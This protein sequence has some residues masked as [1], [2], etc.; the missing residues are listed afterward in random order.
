MHA[1]FEYWIVQEKIRWNNLE[2]IKKF[3]Q[4]WLAMICVSNFNNNS[5]A[6]KVSRNKKGILGWALPPYGFVLC[7]GTKKQ[8]I[9]GSSFKYMMGMSILLNRLTIKN[10]KIPSEK[11]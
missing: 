6:G 4:E 8:L 1:H 9:S 11:C 7:R 2:I 3:T 5:I 10:R